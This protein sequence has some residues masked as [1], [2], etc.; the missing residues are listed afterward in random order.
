M[1]AS[2][3]SPQLRARRSLASQAGWVLVLMAALS[4]GSCSFLIDE[5]TTLDKAG[6]VSAPQLVVPV[7]TNASH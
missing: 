3:P 1:I 6:P 7:G 4:L 5:F 2:T